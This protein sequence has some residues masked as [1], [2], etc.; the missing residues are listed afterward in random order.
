[1]APLLQTRSSEDRSG[2]ID[3]RNWHRLYVVSVASPL[4]GS[5]ILAHDTQTHLQRPLR[6]ALPQVPS[7]KRKTD[8]TCD[9]GVVVRVLTDTLPDTVLR[10]G[11]R[12]LLEDVVGR[13]LPSKE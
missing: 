5:R 6:A 3:V 2:N 1:M 8:L 9:R 7:M 13:C 12:N 4:P 10:A 11:Y